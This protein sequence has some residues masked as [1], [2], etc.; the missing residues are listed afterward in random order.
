MSVEEASVEA[1]DPDKPGKLKRVTM[2]RM[3]AEGSGH[4]RVQPFGPKDSDCG[5]KHV[6][7]FLTELSNEWKQ[8]GF[9]FGIGDIF[10]LA[11]DHKSHK[12]GSAF[13]IYVLNKNKG[14]RRDRYDGT[15]T[16][17]TGDYD[18][19]KTKALAQ[20]IAM[21]A[22]R[23]GGHAGIQQIL[24]NDPKVQEI[25]C[26]PKIRTENDPPHDDHFHLTFS[27]PVYSKVSDAELDRVLG[28]ETPVQ[29][30][31]REFA[32]LIRALLADI[33]LLRFGSSGSLVEALQAILNNHGASQLP[34]LEEDGAFGP[35]TLAR[36]QEF[37]RRNNLVADGVVGPQTKNA[38]AAKY[39]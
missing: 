20:L 1:A 2:Y 39:R 13:D 7:A 22:G 27:N 29:R 8:P 15:P 6:I 36:V 30:T 38:L 16:Y 11:P 21:K 37:Q 35:K 23:Y 17:K 26:D 19:D 9:E 31:V 18:Q 24:Y 12:Y 25:A 32:E 10:S 14:K 28:L 3:P 5:Q 34:P 33:Q 4:Y